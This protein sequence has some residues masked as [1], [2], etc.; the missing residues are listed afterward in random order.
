MAVALVTQFQINPGRNLEFMS[1][2][3]EAKKVHERLGGKVRVWTAS[4]AG[5]NTGNVSYV[6]EHA[7]LAAYA[8][9]TDKLLADTEW[10]A[11]VVKAFSTNPTSRVLGS[12]L[13]TEATV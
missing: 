7:N 10:Q 9:F 12:T 6:I 1:L 13:A 4:V 11:F 5:P 2:V 8:A 3:S